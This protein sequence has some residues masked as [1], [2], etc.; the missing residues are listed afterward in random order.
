LEG[1]DITVSE[2]SQIAFDLLDYPIPFSSPNIKPI[3][4]Y[5]Y[6]NDIT[7]KPRLTSL[8]PALYGKLYNFQKVG[9]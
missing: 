1:K 9:I 8:P 3:I 2:I 5:N 6:Q 7:L 4:K